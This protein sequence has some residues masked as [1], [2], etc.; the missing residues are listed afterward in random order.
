MCL[1]ITVR[2]SLGGNSP[3]N[4]KNH[5]IKKASAGI[6][7]PRNNSGKFHDDPMDSLEV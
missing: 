2:N 6:H 4:K 5:Q 7:I 1:C 3:K